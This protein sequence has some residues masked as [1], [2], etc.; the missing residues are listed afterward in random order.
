MVL[1]TIEW[2]KKCL[3]NSHQ[4]FE[5][6]RKRIYAELEN[7]NKNM[8]RIKFYYQQIQE[9]EKQGKT[10]FDDERFLIKKTKS[11]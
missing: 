11:I 4:F 9:A 5:K 7:H 10:K 3:S 8:E 2:H 6:E 1:E